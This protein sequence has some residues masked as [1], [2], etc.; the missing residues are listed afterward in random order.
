M[1]L[2]TI[3]DIQQV[4]PVLSNLLVSY[5]QADSRFVASRVFPSVPVDF[6]DGTYYVYDKKY[7]FI[8][9]MQVRAPGA[10]FGRNGFGISTGTYSAV[11][12]GLEFP[13]PDE[14]NANNQTPMSMEQAGARWLA[15]NSNLRKEIAWA[16]DFM[17]TGI[18]T[19]QDVNSATDWDDYTNGDPRTNIL[20]AK[21]TIS[22][23]TGF[24]PN[25]MVT[26][27]IVWDAL[28]NHPD[29]IDRIKY[30][31]VATA[32]NLESAMSALLGVNVMVGYAIY[33]TANEGAAFSASAIIDDDALLLYVTSAPTIMEP[34]AG[35]TFTWA[36]G[37][38][39]GAV[40]RYREPQ[41]RS[42]ILQAFESWD[43]VK[44]AA[45]LGY[46]FSDIV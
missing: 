37:G 11:Q 41:T 6:R 32:Q 22:Q 8:D 34:S 10:N 3:N 13:M 33:N 43:Q 35:Y 23:L 25:V 24:A 46:F 15:Q 28:Q 44:V 29:L 38:G 40:A 42:D 26:G 2:P 18:W 9:G 14:I 27:E 5:Q 12:F 7:W 4:D 45:D 17:T 39:A 20:T 21:R 19:S 30:Q 16:T 36:G 1:S 31:Q